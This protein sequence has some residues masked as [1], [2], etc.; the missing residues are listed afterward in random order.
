M[1]VAW[2]YSTELFDESTIRALAQFYADVIQ[3]MAVAPHERLD[4]LAL[5]AALVTQVEQARR[6]ANEAA[7]VVVTSTFPVDSAADALRA[8]LGALGLDPRVQLA[9]PGRVFDDVLA[10]ATHVRWL[11]TCVRIADWL[12]R[13][14]D[15]LVLAARSAA[16]L[17]AAIRASAERTS[18]R[19]LVCVYPSTIAAASIEAIERDLAAALDGVPHVTMLDPRELAMDVARQISLDIRPIA[20]VIVVDGDDTLWTGVC[21]ELGPAA[22]TVDDGR[23]AL[24]H[25][26]LAQRTAGVV[27]CLVSNNAAADIEHVLAEHPDMVLRREHFAHV[28]ASWESKPA[29]LH[30]LSAALGVGLDSFVVLDDDPLACA[31]IRAAAPEVVTY[32]V[33]RASAD[34]PAWLARLWAFDHAAVTADGRARADRYADEARRRALRIEHPHYADFVADLQLQV[35]V[36]PSQ[37]EDIPRLGELLRRTTQFTTAP[38]DVAI[39]DSALVARVR[40]RFG[41]YGLVG[42]ALWSVRDGAAR[43]SAFA[44]SCRALGRGVEHQLI[45]E[46]GRRAERAGERQMSSSRS[47][48][49]HATCRPACSSTRSAS[50]AITRTR[51]PPRRRSACVS[52][53]P[54][55]T[56]CPIF[57]TGPSAHMR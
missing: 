31:A 16:E 23:L 38:A 40:D 6:V 46:L 24:Q 1:R 17:A 30:A 50:D 18:T 42:V 19:H 47:S 34:I 52:F 29:R 33:P 36:A 9:P 39:D 5:P 13:A 7:T 41:D 44:I 2:E 51:S 11:V 22:V 3:H 56:R 32:E 43:V 28:V 48:R 45:V 20:K 12:G 37:T 4:Q 26:L 57:R 10:P 35:T 15:D 27:L 49:P 8:W 14:G 54:N 53:R 55:L 25:A 21:A